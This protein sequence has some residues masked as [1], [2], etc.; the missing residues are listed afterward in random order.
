MKIDTENQPEELETGDPGQVLARH[1]RGAVQRL[2]TE[3]Q[4]QRPAVAQRVVAGEV[5]RGQVRRHRAGHH[6]DGARRR[7]LGRARAA[8]HASSL[9]G[10][11]L[12]RTARTGDG[13]HRQVGTF[14]PC[15]EAVAHG[16]LGS[17]EPV[18]VREH[19][20]AAVG[21]TRGRTMARPV[22]TFLG[23]AGTVTGSRFLVTSR[24]ARCWSTAACSRASASCAGATGRRSR[25]TG[26]PRRR[27][28]DPR[29]PRPQRLPARL[30]RQGFRGPVCAPEGPP[31]GRDRAARQRAP[32][33]GG[34][35]ATRPPPAGPS[36]ARR[37]RSTTA[38]DA[39]RP[40]RCCA[41]RPFGGRVAARRAATWCSARPATSS[42][43]RR[44]SSGRPTVA[45]CCSA[46][47][48]AGRAPAAAARPSPARRPTSWSSSR[49]T[50]TGT[51]PPAAAD[52]LA[53]VIS[54]T[55]AAA[56]RSSSRPSPSTAPRSCWMT[57]TGCA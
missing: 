33:G 4:P 34:R 29:P 20:S 47:T 52:R 23:A 36:T 26:R 53:D 56:A 22:L 9:P 17:E 42:A 16:V 21:S 8:L 31:A 44:P 54:R 43:R 30:A 41:G 2:L 6:R 32:A 12:G 55:V 57:C 5:E 38:A 1:D 40:A 19:G 13:Q 35:R 10:P 28:A 46:V 3:T 15:R 27:R 18:L 51:H 7:P 39:E 37:C 50:A 45:P 25:S 48:W 24:T 14:G 11:R 49:R